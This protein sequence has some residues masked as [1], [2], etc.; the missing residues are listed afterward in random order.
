ML[1]GVQFSSGTGDAMAKE[2]KVLEYINAYRQ[3]GHL[4]TRTNP[5]R[6]RRTYTPPWTW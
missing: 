5:V 6:E 2:F 3:R 4:F 1:P